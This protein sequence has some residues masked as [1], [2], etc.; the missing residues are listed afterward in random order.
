MKE[1]IQAE[2]LVCNTIMGVKNLDKHSDLYGGAFE[3]FVGM[4][5][6]AYLS[7]AGKNATNILA[8]YIAARG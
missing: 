2:A 3:H 5:L 7:Y 6:R 1:E 4:E 8:N